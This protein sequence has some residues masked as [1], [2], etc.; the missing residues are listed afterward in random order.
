MNCLRCQTSMQ[1]KRLTSDAGQPAMAGAGLLSF[2]QTIEFHHCPSCGKVEFFINGD[3][4]KRAA[5]ASPA[6][7]EENPLKVELAWD[8][9]II[10]DEETNSEMVDEVIEIVAVAPDEIDEMVSEVAQETLMELGF[11]DPVMP[12]TLIDEPDDH[13]V[14]SFSD[15]PHPFFVNFPRPVV[16]Q[17]EPESDEV[18][19]EMDV[20]DIDEVAPVDLEDGV[21]EVT[22]LGFERGDPVLDFVDTEELFD[23]VDD[24]EGEELIDFDFD[25]DVE[26]DDELTMI[27]ELEEPLFDDPAELGDL[28]TPDAD[29]V[30]IGL[31]SDLTADDDSAVVESTTLEEN[32][33]E[34]EEE[35]ALSW[36][37]TVIAMPIKSPK[38]END[39]VGEN[40]DSNGADN[41]SEPHSPDRDKPLDAFAEEDSLMSDEPP[42]T[43]VGTVRQ[44]P[45][46]TIMPAVGQELLAELLAEDDK[47][48]G[49]I[50]EAEFEIVDAPD[51]AADLLF[52]EDDEFTADLDDAEAMEAFL[53]ADKDSDFPLEA[54]MSADLDGVSDVSDDERQPDE[55]EAVS[56]DWLADLIVDE[57]AEKESEPDVELIEP[58]PADIA[59]QFGA[60]IDNRDLVFDMDDDMG[61]DDM[62]ALDDLL[63]EL[64]DDDDDDDFDMGII[65]DGA[66]EF[67]DVD[68]LAAELEYL[69]SD[70]DEEAATDV[71]SEPRPLARW[72][73]LVPGETTK[74]QVLFHVGEAASEESYPTGLA[75]RY[76]A[77]EAGDTHTVLIDPRRG[78]VRMVAIY[79]VDGAYSLTD[80][81]QQHGS[82]ELATV[83]QGRGHWLFKE[84]GIGFVSRRRDP[85]DILYVQLLRPQERIVD[86]EGVQGYAAET[87]GGRG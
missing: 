9:P 80:L 60:E 65:G 1:T 66:D 24:D 15:T 63:G 71:E 53:T 49:N 67:G 28:F 82:E 29:E 46:E 77:N 47:D 51:E 56:Q 59:N 30:V 3:A 54:S 87:F 84:K 52:D 11:T 45:P 7:V 27:T 33:E 40:F 70:S 42:A 43:A 16:D 36:L 38:S 74:L 79:N 31:L 44:R 5:M 57:L 61:L 4:D 62:P 13:R 86:Y 85:N 19:V 37:D 18:I 78:R 20:D 2:L 26:V 8:E 22:E 83:V 39:A 81:R 41:T 12:D 50:V 21:E 10:G 23:A 69:E 17:F 73:G 75:L 32:E 48:D 34:D 68:L 55:F 35:D 14:L 72:Q 58:E 6:A 25:I 76:P 64:L